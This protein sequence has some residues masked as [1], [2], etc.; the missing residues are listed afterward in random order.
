MKIF[1]A[2]IAFS[3]ASAAAF[4]QVDYSKLQDNITAV[5]GVQS[6][7]SVGSDK[8]FLDS[9]NADEIEV[10]LEDFLLDKA[11]VYYLSYLYNRDKKDLKTSE[12]IFDQCWEEFQNKRALYHLIV[13][14]RIQ[15]YC[16]SLDSLSNLYIEKFSSPEDES[17]HIEI[18]RMQKQ[19][20]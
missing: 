3:I 17:S 19:C 7:E 10:G 18:E 16:Q 11:W 8:A 12:K 5:C 15:N 4:S 2:L 9:L 1:L 6:R 20:Q 13:F 14:D